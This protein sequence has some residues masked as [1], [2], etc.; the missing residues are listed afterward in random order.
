MG[1]MSL[2]FADFFRAVSFLTLLSACCFSGGGRTSA[3]DDLE[4]SRSTRRGTPSDNGS[5]TD[6][7]LKPPGQE[8]QVGSK[9]DTNESA[10]G[11]KDQA[12]ASE[13]STDSG[14][15]APKELLALRIEAPPAPVAT[16]VTAG[17]SALREKIGRVLDLYYERPENSAERAPW[18]AMHGFISYGVDANILV[19]Q[20][21]VNCIAYLAYN[22]PCRGVRLLEIQNGRP[23][24]RVGVNVQG[25]E[26]QFLAMLA[27]SRVPRDYPL[28]VN[29]QT[30]T[31][32]D[33]IET[34]KKTCKPRTEL[35]FK[36]IGLSHYLDLDS[37]WTSDTGETWSVSRLINEELA[38]PVIG[39]ACG[40]T[41]RLMG[42]SYAARNRE[43]RGGA[44]DGE[45]VRAQKFVR[46]FQAYA[47]TLQNPRGNFSTE[48]FAGR[49]DDPNSRTQL[50]TTGHITEWLAYALTPEEL[51]SARMEKAVDFLADHL[52]AHVQSDL[53]VGPRGHGLHALV[54]YEERRFGARPGERVARLQQKSTTKSR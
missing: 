2:S 23:I 52:L 25:H 26:G 15:D 33:L 48:F 22:N 39:S 6:E 7:K 36:L 16:P 14:P 20:Q 40:G 1:A 3:Q 28:R 30:F 47:F 10:G 42:L 51:A 11:L 34:E 12:G 31:V 17:E 8:G 35:T 44:M 45:W 46:D 18:G 41:H 54:I 21:R 32:A 43:K 38:Q 37:T 49:A 24:A 9:N 5:A 13:K 29:G 27:Q 53:G 4:N 19:N 50:Y